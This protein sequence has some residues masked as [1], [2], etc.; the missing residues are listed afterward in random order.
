MPRIKH[1]LLPTAMIAAVLAA[2]TVAA[3]GQSTEEI[4]VDGQTY[5]I[6]TTAAVRLDPSDGLLAGATPFYIIGFPVAQGTSGPITLPSGYR[7]QNNGLP[8][9]IPYHDHVTTGTPGPSANGTAGHSSASR[10]VVAMRYSWAYAYS[11]S[12]VPIRS[13]D[14][15]AAAEASGKLQAINPGAADPFQIWTTTVLIRP[16]VSAP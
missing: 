6:N 1:L 12:F 5:T 11:P 4:Y 13:V 14:E 2:S 10:R 3:G 16:I 7:P 15:F 8:S 9:P